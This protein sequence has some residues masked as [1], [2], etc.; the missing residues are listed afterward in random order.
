MSHNQLG[1]RNVQ[2][3]ICDLRQLNFI[4]LIHFCVAKIKAKTLSARD[5]HFVITHCPL[6]TYAAT[7][8]RRSVHC[9]MK[10]RIRCGFNNQKCFKFVNIAVKWLRDPP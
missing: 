5:D 4:V 6:K 10:M 9:R 8:K 7:I 2:P 3:A 1:H